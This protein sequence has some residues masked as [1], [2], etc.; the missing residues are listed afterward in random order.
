M[1]EYFA[2]YDYIYMHIYIY[3]AHDW[4]TYVYVVKKIRRDWKIILQ[5]LR[6]HFQ[7]STMEV[8]PRMMN[9]GVPPESDEQCIA[10]SHL[11]D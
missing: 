5:N 11:S 8:A 1:M 2:E 7:I 3:S 6:F 9:A 10:T 4:R